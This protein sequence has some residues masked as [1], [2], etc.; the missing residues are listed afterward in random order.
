MLYDDANHTTYSFVEDSES[1]DGNGDG[2]MTTLGPIQ[3]SRTD[4]PYTY[5][6]DETTYTGAYDETMTMS[7]AVTV[8][9]N[10]LLMPGM[11]G[12]NGGLVD[13]IGS[14]TSGS[15]ATRSIE[16]LHATSSPR[17]SAA[18]IGRQRWSFSRGQQS[19]TAAS[20][21]T[22]VNGSGRM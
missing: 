3:V 13:L 20:I 16:I 14:G 22:V 8:T 12:D 9:D 11:S 21:S 18:A 7:G 15:H 19:A 1:V 5:T 10:E 17:Q 6:R 2:T 4:V